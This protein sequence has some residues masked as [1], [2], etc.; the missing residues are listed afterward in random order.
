MY[1]LCSSALTVKKNRAK[2]GRH[3]VSEIEV[4]TIINFQLENIH[5]PLTYG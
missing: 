1:G 2:F 5:V 4:A 3:V